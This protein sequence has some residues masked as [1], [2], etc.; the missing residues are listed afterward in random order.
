MN[1][2]C[3]N[4]GTMTEDFV[5]AHVVEIREADMP[6]RCYCCIV[7]FLRVGCLVPFSF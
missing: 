1:S 3:D 6:A 7:D 5:A 2:S 4:A